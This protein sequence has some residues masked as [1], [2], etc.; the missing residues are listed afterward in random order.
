MTTPTWMV[1]CL[2]KQLSQI[3]A[4]GADRLRE[5]PQAH[6]VLEEPD[7]AVDTALVREVG[8]C[9]SS[10]NTG[11]V[12]SRPTRDHVPEE[13]YAAV[14]ASS[15]GVPTTADAVSCDPTAITGVDRSTTGVP[16]S[17]ASLRAAAR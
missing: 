1:R 4:P 10:V 3:G 8:E 7:G 2:S 15:I 11:W 5:D 12:S 16:R 14:P 13:T 17:A 6:D 9:A